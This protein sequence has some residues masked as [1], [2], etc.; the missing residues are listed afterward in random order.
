MSN[1]IFYNTSYFKFFKRHIKPKEMEKELINL[2]YSK[3]ADNSSKTDR[4]NYS[5]EK[6]KNLNL[7]VYFQKKPI[8]LI[9]K[10]R[11][12][13]IEFDIDKSNSFDQNEFYH[14]FNIN[15]IP[16]KMDEI[17]YLFNFNKQKKTITF[18][19]LIKLTFDSD[20][21]KR[22]K[23]IISKVKTRCE[24]G[25]ICPNDFSEMLS[26]L[27]EFGKLSS[28]V[29]N[30]RKELLRSKRKNTLKHINITE[31]NRQYIMGKTKDEIKMEK[32]SNNH[33]SEDTIEKKSSKKISNNRNRSNLSEMN[34][35]YQVLEKTHK[36][37]EENDNMINYIK[38]IIEITK[39]KI[40]RNEQT[41]KNLN[42]RSEIE[43]SKRN[44]A[45]SI[46]ILHKINPKINNAYISYCPLNQK[47]IDLNT[48]KGYDFNNIKDYKYKGLN[49][50]ITKNILNYKPII[51]EANKSDER[52]KHKKF[53][54]QCLLNKKGKKYYRNKSNNYWKKNSIFI[55]EN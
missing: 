13:F 9:N 19:E 15:K 45:K 20:F 41:F 23:V 26:H 31:S 4:N 28:D 16:I 42:Y 17:K 32:E 11:D 12:L 29:K 51:T 5:K 39:K 25:F 46:D 2:I 27:C 22:Y 18:S 3:K 33:M 8:I 48:G 36:M 43:N 6:E 50:N 10:I 44:L 7:N 35:D 55:N 40:V 37:K 24:K 53:F 52:N 34:S 30:Y 49:N 54:K 38:T 1:N 14:M 21:D 47:F